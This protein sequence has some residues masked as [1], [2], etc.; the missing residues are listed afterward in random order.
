MPKSK[1]FSRTFSTVVITVC[2]SGLIVYGFT[3]P[4][5]E[6]RFIHNAEQHARG[7]LDTTYELIQNRYQ[8]L[9]YY[10]DTLIDAKKRELVRSIEQVN[11]YINQLKRRVSARLVSEQQAHELL[12][13]FV[14]TTTYGNHD[15]FWLLNLDGEIIAHPD[16]RFNEMQIRQLNSKDAQE[17]LSNI[18][19]RA[20]AEGHGFYHYSWQRLDKSERAE[21]ISYYRLIPDWNLVLGTGVYMDDIQSDIETRKITLVNNLRNFILQTRIGQTGY[22]YVFNSQQEMVIHPNNQLEGRNVAQMLNPMTGNPLAQDIIDA[23]ITLEKKLIYK[24]DKLDDKGNFGYEKIAWVDYFPGFDWYLSTSVYVDELKAEASELTER[25]ILVTLFLLTTALVAAYMYLKRLTNP[26]IQ[27]AEDARRITQGDLTVSSQ[28]QRSDEIGIL[29]NAFNIMV[30]KLRGQIE[31]L[32]TRVEARTQEL[33]GMVHNLEKRNHDIE[34]LNELSQLVQSCESLDDLYQ[35]VQKQLLRLFNHDSGLLLML[36]SQGHLIPR[37]H[38]R[39]ESTDSAFSRSECW[40]M[41]RSETHTEDGINA[42]ACSCALAQSE[43]I[44]LCIPL[45]TRDQIL[46]LLHI[47]VSAEQCGVANAT[48]SMEVRRCSDQTL[49]DRKR[50]GEAVAKILALAIA[51]IQLRENLKRESV[52]DALTGLQNRRYF[53][54]LIPRELARADRKQSQIS[55]LMLDVDHFKNVNDQFGHSVGD[56]L[57]TQLGQLL[58][59][60]IRKEDVACRYGGEEFVI[61]MPDSDLK[62]A[63]V[64]A[65]EIRLAVADNLIARDLSSG[66][67]RAVTISIGVSVYPIH[68]T[69]PDRLLNAADTALYQAKHEGRNKVC[70]APAPDNIRPIQSPAK[71]K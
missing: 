7:T 63:S 13:D 3:I 43:N 49:K 10:E 15:Y 21:K 51:N 29:A 44:T 23:S 1:L 36:D 56:E 4:W 71:P 11:A 38:W 37:L 19:A 32:E 54:E 12:K 31:A 58:R 67:S 8:E 46:G 45:K 64:R 42:P 55:L 16:A 40:A 5:M 52:M 47:R 59:N 53:N 60:H 70:C 34:L 62:D 50:L 66:R 24:W 30:N 27:L 39:I 28:I 22:M 48:S 17:T 41:R 33:S 18:T 14:R 6:Q 68:G 35:T 25:I 69:T 2:L 57:L 9:K 65:N 61:I 26:V 20:K